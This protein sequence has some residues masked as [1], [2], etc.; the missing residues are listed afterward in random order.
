VQRVLQE[1][2]IPADSVG[3]HVLCA[4]GRRIPL[5]SV[6]ADGGRILVRLTRTP[7]F[8]YWIHPLRELWR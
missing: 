6:P 3:N 8:I 5:A 1:F 7:L 4:G 2:S